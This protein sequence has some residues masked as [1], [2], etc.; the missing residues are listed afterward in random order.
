MKKKLLFCLMF[1]ALC[2]NCFAERRTRI[3][4]YKNATVK[5]I[6]DD[7]LNGAPDSSNWAKGQETKLWKSVKVNQ[8]L[9]P[10]GTMDMVHMLTDFDNAKYRVLMAIYRDSELT[11]LYKQDFYSYNSAIN[12]FTR[13][14]NECEETLRQYAKRRR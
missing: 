11:T 9:H 4:K 8:F 1:F 6:W 12:T 13:I 3:D 5:I 7:A 2:A 14:S 10:D